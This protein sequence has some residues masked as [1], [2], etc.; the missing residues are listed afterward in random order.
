MTLKGL[1]KLGVDALGE[2]QRSV[3][4]AS[5]AMEPERRIDR[6][7]ISLTSGNQSS[8]ACCDEDGLH[9]IMDG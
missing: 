4:G 2:Q 8:T 5:K 6:G 3:A 9:G 7:L 1:D